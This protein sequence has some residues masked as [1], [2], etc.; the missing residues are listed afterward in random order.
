MAIDFFLG[1]K[2]QEEIRARLTKWRSMVADINPRNFGRKEAL[3]ASSLLEKMFGR[4]FSEHRVMVL[5]A[6]YF[7]FFAFS[8][9]NELFLKKFQFTARGDAFEF[10]LD[11]FM[12][13]ASIS[14]TISFSKFTA[15]IIPTSTIL[16]FL[17]FVLIYIIQCFLMSLSFASS[18]FLSSQL[19][20]LITKYAVIGYSS[21]TEYFIILIKAGFSNFQQGVIFNP[22]I[23]LESMKTFLGEN[24]NDLDLRVVVALILSVSLGLLRLGIAVVFLASLLFRPMYRFFDLFALRLIEEKK[25]IFTALFGGAAAAVKIVIDLVKLATGAPV[26]G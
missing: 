9:I 18:A 12:L 22:F 4:F 23:L 16:N 15:R 19:M 17:Y 6:I 2:R 21:P 14:A 3:W 11:A 20:Q 5:G 7:P 25:P 13:S 26:G 24:Y 8:I 1:Q 10:L